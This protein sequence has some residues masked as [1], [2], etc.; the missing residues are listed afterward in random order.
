MTLRVQHFIFVVR[1][2]RR[3]PVRATLSLTAAV[4][5]WEL[6]SNTP[7]RKNLK[8]GDLVMFYVAG[9]TDPDA[10]KVIA[11]AVVATDAVAARGQGAS[12]WIGIA[13]PARYSIQLHSF[14]WITPP[15]PVRPLLP[16][17]SFVRNSG[18]WGTH[19]Q[20]G[21]VKIAESDA[22]LLRGA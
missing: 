1:G 17:L 5:R 12:D 2:S 10:H 14:T 18:R 3:K 20:G 8:P 7:H 9:A 19:F 15:V 4:G 21:V 11:S 13:P 16:H 6:N 22:E